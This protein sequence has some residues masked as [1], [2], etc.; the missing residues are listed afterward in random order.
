MDVENA[1]EKNKKTRIKLLSQNG[2]PRL[3]A[4]YE[5]KAA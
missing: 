1:A 3:P 4:F 5:N 2:Y